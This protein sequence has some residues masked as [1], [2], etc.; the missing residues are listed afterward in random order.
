MAFARFSTDQ[1]VLT[2][3]F[4]AITA[5]LLGASHFCRPH[6]KSLSQPGRGTL[7]LAPLLPFWEKGLGAG[8]KFTKVRCTPAITCQSVFFSQTGTWRTF[9]YS[10]EG[11]IVET[12]VESV[13]SGAAEK[14]IVLA[15]A[16]QSIVSAT[17]Q[18]YQN[19]RNDTI[20]GL[21]QRRYI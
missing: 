17:A 2:D 19:L 8:G 7:N 4:V 14:S 1:I 20:S 18:Q 10:D 6:P 16:V 11:V 15:A 21:T 5:P 13:V 3:M 12:A 9:V